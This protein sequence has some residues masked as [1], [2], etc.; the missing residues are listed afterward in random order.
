M[1]IPYADQLARTQVAGSVDGLAD[2]RGPQVL[3]DLY[4]GIGGLSLHWSPPGRR[5]FGVEVA[6]DA[7]ASANRSQ[8][9][10]ACK[11]TIRVL[12]VSPRPDFVSPLQTEV[13]GHE[14]PARILGGVD[15][16]RGGITQMND[17][18]SVGGEP[19]ALEVRQISK[20]YRRQQVLDDVSFSLH[21]GRSMAIIG[22]NGCG[23]STLL[24][25]CA[26]LISPDD[27]EVRVR[28][29]LGYCPQ[30]AD[31]GAF[32]TPADHFTWFGAPHGMSRRASHEEGQRLAS[33]LDWN[34][35]PRQVRHL[36]GGTAQKL[37]VACAVL[38]GPQVILL[39]E[40]YQG[41]DEGSYLD[42][43]D[44]V[45]RW[46]AQGS[47]VVVVTH[48]LRELHRVNSVLDLGRRS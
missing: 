24:K 13:V 43:W 26:G 32:L 9:S 40:P 6:P 1:G 19:P 7:V 12:R 5:V 47:A 31:L 3:W 38:G 45:D 20:S 2:G 16:S 29:R 14:P 25:I 21:P 4:C 18:V 10:S 23:K 15:D 39:D 17:G 33:S 46:C 11:A 27:G 44:L 42:F 30:D 36:S 28:G 37:N 34:V 8:T 41:F 22:A 48:L 35:A